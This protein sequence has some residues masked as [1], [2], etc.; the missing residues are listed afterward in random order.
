MSCHYKNFTPI[1]SLLILVFLCISCSHTEIS[2]KM[3]FFPNKDANT[4]QT[5]AT[6]STSSDSKNKH[7]V[8]YEDLK[9]K[10]LKL[11]DIIINQ[12]HDEQNS[13][14]KKNFGKEW[15]YNRDSTRPPQLGLALSG[16]GTRSASFSIG[17]MKALHERGIL[18]NVDIMSS[19]SGGSYALYWYYMQNLNMDL[20]KEGKAGECSPE[21]KYTSIFES[22]SDDSKDNRFQ[23]HLESNSDILTILT[24]EESS[25]TF[26]NW[27]GQASRLATSLVMLP[28]N[29]GFNGVFDWDMNLFPYRRYYQNGLERTYG[30]SPCPSTPE[31]KGKFRNESWRFLSLDPYDID[32]NFTFTEIKRALDDRL[33]DSG[34]CTGDCPTK[35]FNS[36]RLPFFVI[37]ATAGHGRIGAHYKVNKELDLPPRSLKRAAPNKIFEF[38]PL[39]FGSEIFGYGSFDENGPGK[40]LNEDIHFSRAVSISGAA[41]DSQ[42]FKNTG[43]SAFIGQAMSS[44]NLNLGYKIDNYNMSK[45]MVAGTNLLPYPFYLLK[46]SVMANPGM[47]LNQSAKW[48]QAPFMLPSEYSSRIHLSDGGQSEVLATLSLIRRGVKNIIMVDAEQ[49]NNKCGNFACF[50]GL[51]YLERSL[52]K[53]YKMDLIINDLKRQTFDVRNAKASV[54]TGGIYKE[55]QINENGKLINLTYIKLSYDKTKIESYPPSI[56]DWVTPPES[57]KILTRIRKKIKEQVQE[58]V[59]QRVEKKL[60]FTFDKKLDEAIKKEFKKALNE[61]L[62]KEVDGEIKKKQKKS[63]NFPHV[64]TA[65]VFFQKGQFKAYRD[66]GY[67]LVCSYDGMSSNSTNKVSSC[68]TG[69]I[70]EK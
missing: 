7:K 10:R 34:D 65:D 55:N 17:V 15:K 66:L 50:K 63:K 36:R 35:E 29:T 19:V 20:Y 42:S 48:V 23:N 30:L 68:K 2:S 39:S 8:K 70:S 40:N 24:P 53:D 22:D 60:G 31:N 58:K 18:Q 9:E 37:N 43:V 11:A 54:F 28:F 44:L 52:K 4:S 69:S 67:N 21:G 25:R 27:V 56:Q 59:K 26:V 5:N 46:H 47:V 3:R 64:S 62:I 38:T 16:G 12:T 6:D 13:V 61:E 1:F 45:D 32:R 49:D 41:V 33:K 57:E 14:L 51:N